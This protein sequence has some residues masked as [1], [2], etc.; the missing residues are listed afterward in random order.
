MY[1]AGNSEHESITVETLLG[2]AMNDVEA[3]NAPELLF[4]AGSMKLPL[5]GPKVAIV[6][7]RQPSEMGLKTAYRISS[8]LAKRGVTIV[9]GLAKGI[10]AQ[11]HRGAIDSGGKTVAVL[12]TPL[13]KTYPRENSELQMTMSKTQLLVS[14][15]PIGKPIQRR[16]FVMRNRTLALLC[17]ASVIIEAGE[18]SGT[19]SQGWEALRLGRP[20]F[21][22][23]TVFDREELSWPSTF[24]KYGA[25]EFSSAESILDVL[26]SGNDIDSILMQ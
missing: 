6:G 19:L 2:R 11:A 12:G 8:E 16:N 17:D 24:V 9:S 26:P 21:I 3:K 13:N 14:Q 23:H 4:A 15:F 20:L 10:D 5:A 7:A 18:S 22:W 25:I 1:E